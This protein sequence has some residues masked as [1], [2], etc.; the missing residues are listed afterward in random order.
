[1]KNLSSF[2]CIAELPLLFYLYCVPV[3]SWTLLLTTLSDCVFN[4]MSNHLD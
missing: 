1:M 4:C 2:L 3:A